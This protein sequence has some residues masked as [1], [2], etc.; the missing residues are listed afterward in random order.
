MLRGLLATTTGGLARALR[1]PD[2]R[3]TVERIVPPSSVRCLAVDPH[4]PGVVYGGTRGDGVLR[5]DDD[6]QTWQHAGLAGQTITALAI[7]PMEPETIYAG[8]RPAR[9]IVTRDGGERWE[10]LPGFRR[11]PLRWL[12]FSPAEPPF[13]AY[14]QAIAPSPADPMILVVGVEAG[15]TV[16]SDDGGQT[17]SRHRRGSLRDCHS[18]TFH[19]TNPGWVYEAGGTGAGVS[20]S[21][22]AGR[23]WTQRRDGL[24]R[25]YGWACAAD[26]DRPEVWYASLAPGPRQAHGGADAQA[27]IVRATDQ[28]WERLGGGLPEPLGSMPYGLLTDPAAAGHLYAVLANGGAWHSV[29]HGDHWEPLPIALGDVH[30]SIVAL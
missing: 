26:P 13:S 17:W 22:D 15:A 10:E 24:D 23:T 12:W 3:W 9:L 28:G 27:I 11:I 25:H 8:T 1:D 2:G 4:H 14:V 16:R 5:S 7:S 30:R 18:L 21:R 29:D 20:C 6:G 19:A